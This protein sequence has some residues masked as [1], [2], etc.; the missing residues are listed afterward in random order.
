ML[1]GKALAALAE[2]LSV[3]PSTHARQWLTVPITSALR[4]GAS[5]TSLHLCAYPQA[6]TQVLKLDVVL[7]RP[8]PVGKVVHTFNP[9]TPKAQAEGIC[10]F[11]A[12]LVYIENSMLSMLE[13]QTYI[14]RT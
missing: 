3:V 7:K 6:D 8:T 4:D 10:D 5:L 2:D 1:S 14:E 13:I 12:S 11:K 9:S